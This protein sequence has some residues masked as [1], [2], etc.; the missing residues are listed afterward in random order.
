M[1]Q[2]FSHLVLLLCC[3]G[4]PSLHQAAEMSGEWTPAPQGRSGPGAGDP[5]S[6][7]GA[8]GAAGKQGG[9][10]AVCGTCKDTMGN[11]LE[12]EWV[13]GSLPNCPHAHQLGCLYTWQE[14]Q[15]HQGLSPVSRPPHIL[16][17]REPGCLNSSRTSQLEP[18]RSDTG[19]MQ[20]NGCCPSTSGCTDLHQLPAMAP[21]RQ[22]AS[23]SEV[24]RGS[25]LEGSELF[26]DRALAMPA[27]VRTLTDPSSSHHSLP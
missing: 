24:P 16:G 20:G 21:S 10:M 17:D 12:T 8:R 14:N 26:T 15:H 7:P 23:G 19:F 13:C 18:A 22:L 11:K 5:T 6:E 1:S 4:Y 3:Y 27:G 2:L 25:Q 9:G